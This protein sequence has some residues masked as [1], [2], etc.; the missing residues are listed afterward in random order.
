MRIGAHTAIAAL[1]GI[2]GSTRIGKHCVIAGKVGIADQLEICDGVTILAMTSVGSSI[3]K[4]GVY[5]GMLAFDEVTQF[6][7]NA[8]RFRHLDE[9]A[10]DLNRMKRHLGTTGIGPS[11]PPPSAL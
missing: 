11:Q 3:R 1:V 10:K 8:V 6:R 4:P 7:R 9:M 2:A 5:S